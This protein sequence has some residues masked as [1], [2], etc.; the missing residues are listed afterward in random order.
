[1]PADEPVRAGHQHPH[2]GRVSSRSR[3]AS[4]IMRTKLGEADPRLPPELAPRLGGIG[5]EQ[6]HL[7][8]PLESGVAHDVLLPVEPDMVEGH[9]HQLAHAVG[10]AG[11]DHVVLG[12]RLLQ[13]PPHRVDVIAGVAPVPASVEIAQPKLGGQAVLDAGDPVGDLAGDELDPP[14]RRLVVEQ[15]PAH[16]EEPVRLPVVH[17]DP[18]AV[19]L[20]HPVGRAGVE[21]GGLPLRRLVHLAEHLG[22]A[23][24]VEPGGRVDQPDRFQHPGHA[25]GGELAGEDGLGVGGGDVGLGGQVVHLVRLVILEHHREGVLVQQ[26]G[27]DDLDP[28]EQVVDPLVA[29]VAGTAHHPDHVVPLVQEQLGQVGPVLSGHSGDERLR[30]GAACSR[31]VSSCSPG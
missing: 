3:S 27:R 31:V 7:G 5:Q 1:M 6:V 19:H 11:A 23:G 22:G 4:T 28:V 10:F 21:V 9:L 16:R 2:R 17:R 30:H 18:V 29:V 15:D 8:R 13:H 25:E 12:G 24:L 14:P 26:V 20:G